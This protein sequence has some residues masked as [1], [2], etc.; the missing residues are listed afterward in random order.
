[1]GCY[2]TG[3]LYDAFNDGLT[4][5]VTSKISG[6]FISNSP[7]LLMNGYYMFRLTSGMTIESCA[8]ICHE[9]LFLFS[10][11]GRY[12]LFLFIHLTRNMPCN[13]INLKSKLK[14]KRGMVRMWKFV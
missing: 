3:R 6:S 10:G 13:L 5:N 14:N 4:V 7:Y 9:N 8:K 2:S 11:L 12:R 1:M